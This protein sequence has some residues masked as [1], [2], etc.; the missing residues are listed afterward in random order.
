MMT[1]GQRWHFTV[2]E[3]EDRSMCSLGIF[4][5]VCALCE[6]YTEPEVELHN[7]QSSTRSMTMFFRLGAMNWLKAIY[8]TPL[9]TKKLA[10]PTT[11]G[12]NS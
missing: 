10:E 7:E 12:S 5:T 8:I 3:P 2:A 6:I 4:N 11:A 9:L 1:P